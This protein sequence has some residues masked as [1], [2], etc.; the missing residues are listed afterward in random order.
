MNSYLMNIHHNDSEKFIDDPEY[1]P[2]LYLTPMRTLGQ[3]Y[4]KN[5]TQVS[6]L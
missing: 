6:N 5:T 2:V 1:F 3:Q 4:P